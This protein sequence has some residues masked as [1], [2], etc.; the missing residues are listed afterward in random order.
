MNETDRN[1]LK[2]LVHKQLSEE[3]YL[4]LLQDERVEREMRTQWQKPVSEIDQC[5]ADRI[6]KGITVAIGYTSPQN[7]MA[8][9]YKVTAWIASILLLL[10][11]GAYFYQQNAAFQDPQYIYV[12]SSGVRSFSTVTLSDG[13]VVKMGPNSQLTYSKV[14]DGAQRDVELKGQAFFEV[15]KNP[16]QPFVVHTSTVDVT[17]LGTAFEVFDYESEARMETILLEGKVRVQLRGSAADHQVILEPDKMFVYDRDTQRAGIKGVNADAYSGW[18]NGFLY[19][20]NE[21][22]NMILPRLETWYGRTIHC[23]QEIADRYRFTFKV[24]DESLERI[25][26]LLS[27]SSPVRFRE[28]NEEYELYI[29]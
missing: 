11:I 23:P 24:R 1:I 5:A 25:L 19:F 15:A 10:G 14:F 29:P 13:T 12:Q 26:Y 4:Q 18:R 22:L 21:K 2:K 7:R 27:T 3:A 20:E 28:V 6:W 16:E 9:V 17:A 8:L